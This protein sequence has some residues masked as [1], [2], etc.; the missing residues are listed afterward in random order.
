MFFVLFDVFIVFQD[1]TLYSSIIVINIFLWRFYIILLF[2]VF[3]LSCSRTKR[4]WWCPDVFLSCCRTKHCL[5][6]SYDVSIPGQNAADGAL[7][8]LYSVFQDKTLLIIICFLFQDKTMLMVFIADYF[9]IWCIYRVPG[10]NNVQY[11]ILSFLFQDKTLLMVPWLLLFLLSQDK[12]LLM[13]PWC[14]I[15]PCCRTKPS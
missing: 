5:L 1:K 14:T 6:L 11:F 4:C 9:N 8:F 7:M 13:V 3:L 10:Q 2:D 15:L 12:S